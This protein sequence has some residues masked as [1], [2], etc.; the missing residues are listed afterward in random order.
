MGEPTALTL[1]HITDLHFGWDGA[2]T[3]LRAERDACLTGL[4]A[5]VSTLEGTW[6]PAVICLSGDIGWHGAA[7]DYVAAKEWL[8]RLLDTC[9][10]GY[11][12][13]IVCAGNHDAAR[14]EARKNARPADPSEADEVLGL[15]LGSQYV[16]PF[17]QMVEFCR[18]AGIVPLKISEDESH[19]VGERLL[20]GYRFVC[21]NSAWF[22][23][24]DKD[25]KE[26]VARPATLRA[27]ESAGQLPLVRGKSD[28]PCTIAL[29]HHPKEWL[30]P[31]ESHAWERRPNTW[32]YLA[33][34][35]HVL[36]TGHTHG[37]VRRA[38]RVAEGVL[39]FTRGSA[40]AGASHFNSF[41]LLRLEPDQ[42]RYVSYEFDPRSPE[43]EW[44]ASREIT[45]P[46]A[47]GGQSANAAQATNRTRWLENYAKKL[48]AKFLAHLSQHEHLDRAAAESRYIDVLTRE[49]PQRQ[50]EKETTESEPRPISN[51][52]AEPGVRALVLGG[53]GS[54]KTS[55]LRKLAVDCCR[56]ALADSQA[57]L[58][59]FGRSE[60]LRHSFRRCQRASR[61]RRARSRPFQRRRGSPVVR[62]FSAMPVPPGRPE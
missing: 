59:L 58:P 47:A 6:K 12:K 27:L 48:E 39:H 16:A 7:T 32:D 52:A 50:L 44:K 36:L 45:L 20:D 14:A 4:L 1:L 3:N 15:P 22:C 33:G 38:D 37:E 30:H 40:Y 17:T 51:L 18:T 19:L 43:N 60:L 11:D 61:H 9:G 10:I 25:E 2:D 42:L 28:V 56:A 29:V 55:I 5:A 24:D 57:P 46:L 62:Q 26:T 49:R 53:G 31:H 41:R 8:D 54:G 21:L 34:R 35:C 13:L 23:K